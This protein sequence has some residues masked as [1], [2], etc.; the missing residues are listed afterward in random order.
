M[1]VE[2][3]MEYPRIR[4]NITVQIQESSGPGGEYEAHP[5]VPDT[6]FLSYIAYC[7]YFGV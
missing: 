7:S 1:V 2:V 6:Q 5:H 3:W 4:P